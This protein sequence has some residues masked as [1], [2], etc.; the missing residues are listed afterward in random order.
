VL[1]VGSDTDDLRRIA[2]SLSELGVEIEDEVLV[3]KETTCAYSPFGPAD[4]AREAMLTD[5]VSRSGDAEV[6]EVTV[7]PEAAI[8]GLSLREAA[9]RETLRD[10]TLVIAIE[11]DDTVLTPHGDTEIR[12]DDIV[13]VFSR[14]GVTEEMLANFSSTGAGDP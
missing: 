11:R 13:T 6:A 5:F 14:D 8:A 1:A 7:D 12:P 4:E 10:E 9:R 3:Q 2:R